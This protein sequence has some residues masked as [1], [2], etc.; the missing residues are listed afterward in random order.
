MSICR[1]PSRRFRRCRL[2]A[3]VASLGLFSTP[4]FSSALDW[5]PDSGTA[6]AQGGSGTWSVDPLN[7]NWNN[8]TGNV[9]WTDLESAVV[10]GTG[11]TVT[12][13]SSAGAIRAGSLQFE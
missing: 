5:D 9:A 4:Q 3:A 10:G 11:G 1:E 6:G 7:M 12:L 13:N 8:G 2:W